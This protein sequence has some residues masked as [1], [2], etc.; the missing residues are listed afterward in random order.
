MFANILAPVLIELADDLQRVTQPG[1]AILLAGLI[2]DQ[3]DR[4]LIA[5]DRCDVVEIRNNGAW[6]GIVL[7]HRED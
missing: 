6:R 4:V 5:F 7:R 3:V 1:G 2:D